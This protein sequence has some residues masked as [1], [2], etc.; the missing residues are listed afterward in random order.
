MGVGSFQASE[1]HAR[2]HIQPLGLAYRFATI[3]LEV[4]FGVV[5]QL[6]VIELFAANHCGVLNRLNLKIKPTAK[7]G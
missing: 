4:G 2:P 6:Q 3:Y 5:I 1:H 7:K